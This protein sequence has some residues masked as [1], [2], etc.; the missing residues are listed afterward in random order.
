MYSK[1]KVKTRRCNSINLKQNIKN[2]NL[3]KLTFKTKQMSWFFED[4][5]GKA[6]MVDF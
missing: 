5:E 2:Q 6:T 3:G 4:E 1:N